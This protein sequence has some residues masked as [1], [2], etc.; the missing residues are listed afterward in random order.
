MPKLWALGTTPAHKAACRLLEKAYSI[1]DFLEPDI[2]GVLLDVPSFRSP[3]LTPEALLS[4]LPAGAAIIGGNLAAVKNTGH[5]V[6]DLL[7]DSEYAAKNADITA[8]CA[9]RLACG[10][11]ERTLDALPVLVIGWGRIGKCL[12]K[13]LHA[14]GAQVTVYARQ[15]KDRAMLA[16]L[17]YRV[18]PDAPEESDLTQ[19]RLIFNTAPA[20]VLSEE[21]T[22]KC[23]SC[24]LFDLASTP[25]MAGERVITARGLP[26]LLAPESSGRLIAQTVQRLW[27]EEM[28]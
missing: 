9:I 16:A 23:E 21:K 25:G 11:L 28:L 8:R 20:P 7:T 6:I 1:T 12:A 15:P 10:R 27:K 3:L 17:G 24:L 5:P 18:L 22:E 19:F 14:L 13:H 4:Q 2:A 26:G